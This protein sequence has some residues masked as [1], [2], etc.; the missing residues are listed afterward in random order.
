MGLHQCGEAAEEGAEAAQGLERTAHIGDHRNLG[1]EQQ[2]GG[3]CDGPRREEGHRIEI[4]AFMDHM[5]AAAKMGRKGIALKEG[6]HHGGI[7]IGDGRQI[8]QVS[9]APL[10]AER[11]RSL[12]EVGV[13]A[14]A[15]QPGLA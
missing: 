3:K 7:G 14:V 15:Q 12:A 8:H 1:L 11:Q 2:A 6:G 4:D 5:K 9:A 10:G 13:K